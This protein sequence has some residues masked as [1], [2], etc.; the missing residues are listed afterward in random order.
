M[1]AF[2]EPLKELGQFDEITEYFQDPSG[3]IGLTGCVDSQKL[4]LIYG[5]SQGLRYRVIVTYS[6]ARARELEE[7]CKLYE[8]NTVI[9]PA[10]DLIFFQ[11]D[12][13]GNELTRQRLRTL[14]MLLEKDSL[15]VITTFDA[16]MAPQIAPERIWDHM[17]EL[18]VGSLL[19]LKA[20]SIRLVEL[21]YENVYQVE[22][23]GQFSIRGGILDIFDLTE[24]NPCRIELWGDEIDSIRTFDVTTQRSIEMLKKAVIYP[25]T[26]MIL[27]GREMETGIA[28]MEKEVKKQADRFRKKMQTEEAA[29]VERQFRELRDNALEFGVSASALNLE[30][31]IRYFYDDL[32]SFCEYFPEEGTGW[33]VEE[34]GRV[35][36]S[37]EVIF[38]EFADS[39]KHRLEKRYILPGQ[40]KLLYTP[41]ETAV[42]LSH[43]RLA[44]FSALDLKQSLF[45]PDHKYDIQAR[46]IAPYNN[47][48]DHLLKD[49]KRFRKE[50]YR[51]L[52]VSGS[53]TRAK[54]LAE[55][56][57]ELELPAFYSEDES[58]VLAE[59][60]IMTCY[61]ALVKGF[62]YPLL[63]FAVIAESDIFGS[64]KKKK[65]RFGKKKGQGI[66]D[67]HELSVGDYV[68]H[69]T[70][71]LGIYQGIEQVEVDHVVK[72]YMKIAYRDG[73]HLFI[74]ATGVDVIQKYAAAE[75]A[76]PK[77]N[78]LGGQE[79]NRTKSKV[80]EAVNE[81][82]EDLVK[83][84]ASRSVKEGFRY[85]PD[86]VWQREF[87]ELFPY[88]ETEDQ[89]AAIEA[90]KGD[91][92]S[93]RIMD[94][95]ICGD[96]GYGKTEVAIRAAFKAVQDGKQVAYLVPTTILAQQH[97]NTFVQRMKDYPV[98]VELVSRFR[99]AAQ[100][101]KTIEGLK[102]GQVDIAIGTHRL[103]S[104]DVAFKDLGLLIIDEEQR[105]GVSDKEKIKKFRE[106][107][108]VLTLTATP[109]PRTL[110]MSLIGIR[111]MSLLE[112]APQERVPIQ[113]YVMEYN[114]EMVREAIVREL[115]RNG[116][117]YYVY[118]QV[119]DIADMAAKIQALVPEAHVA[120]A[121]GQMSERELEAMMCRFIDGEVDVLV[122]TTIIETGLDISNVNT[123]IIHHSDRMGL[124]QLY[125]LRGRVGRSNRT[126]YAFLMY[127]KDK[128]LSEVAEKRLAAIREFT[129][130]GSGF[131]IAMKDL[132]I[133]GAG[134]MLGTVQHGHME[135]VGYDMYCKML[136]EAVRHLKDEDAPE[137]FNTFVDIDTDA[138]IP[139]EY[140]LNEGQKMDIYKRI[141][142]IQTK[143][144]SNEIRDEMKD[145]FGKVPES[146]ENLLRIAL[147]RA[148]AH[149]LF[150]TEIKGKAGSL[151]VSLLATAPVNVD[152]IPLL[153]ADYSGTL[154]FAQGKNPTF[155]Y[156]FKKYDVV[157][158]DSK[159]LLERCERL[160][161]D[162]ERL[163]KS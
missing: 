126:A 18:E 160:L 139:T 3:T 116:Q 136:S 55:D 146:A 42:L 33:F 158:K 74:P 24:E 43:R 149:K 97:Y 144:E 155:T 134:T 41:Q 98:R 13:H 64:E 65:M 40:M 2:L 147:L 32:T 120:Y 163:F 22:S 111:D 15:T 79:W 73:G 5:I 86:T 95:L 48:F 110:H 58:R 78:K 132:E 83:L 62:E 8:P 10:K 81:V 76:V 47:H 35:A 148:H 49:L 115:S 103:L 17:L 80:K 52:L 9:F 121:H 31:H 37:A 1:K 101:K 27:S 14:K 140:I 36:E 23:P 102:T 105:F 138:Y 71:G 90:A 85:G 26:E 151:K 63:R 59:G 109:I 69:E 20:A 161:N 53:R 25:A 19:D 159:M 91:M 7:D 113:T 54:R 124:A 89:L 92:E 60:E 6:E 135:A 38:A 28:K 93:G 127:Q 137:D 128:I 154:S 94:R 118:N 142:G 44:L 39:M 61:G 4:N 30:G 34:P 46:N 12:I 117:I 70:H 112:E 157:E 114:D 87:E 96:V 77:L 104:K 84:Y 11:A 66:R 99:S 51:V 119:R 57:T 16:L 45:R 106:C 29:R 72:D 162:F 129:E 125:Q 88:E 152:M 143:A 133:R 75:G 108:D 122:S 107:V 150:V 21:G 68:V 156:K 50:N 100:N 130:L 67:F 56:L 141:A 153:L 82:A 145:R 123:I 131:K